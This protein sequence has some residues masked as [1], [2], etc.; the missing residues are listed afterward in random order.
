MKSFHNIIKIKKLINF[1]RLKIFKY[2]KILTVYIKK[3]FLNHI[4]TIFSIYYVQNIFKIFFK[5][6]LIIKYLKIIRQENKL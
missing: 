5:H 2:I 3:I 4:T 6:F 1:K